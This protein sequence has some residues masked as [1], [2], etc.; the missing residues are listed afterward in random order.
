MDLPVC[1]SL[2]VL[3]CQLYGCISMYRC[4]VL[5]LVLII[6][7]R[8]V[9]CACDNTMCMRVYA[10]S[11]HVGAFTSSDA[12]PTMVPCAVNHCGTSAAA[13]VQ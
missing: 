10:T 3:K 5:I 1:G 8:T 9:P 13:G 12:P 2:H 6:R 7:H 4:H 11:V